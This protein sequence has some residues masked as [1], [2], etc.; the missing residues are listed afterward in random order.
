MIKGQITQD[1]FLTQTTA[2][3]LRVTL[4]STIEMSRYLLE[5]CNFTYVLTGKMNQDSLEV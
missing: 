1:E 4:R 2:E 3:G 5:K